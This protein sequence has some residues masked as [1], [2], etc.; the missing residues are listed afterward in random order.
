MKACQFPDNLQAYPPTLAPP[1]YDF[2]Q[3]NRKSFTKRFEEDE[4]GG[5]GEG[6]GTAFAQKGALLS[7]PAARTHNFLGK[8][9]RRWRECVRI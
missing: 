4:G 2:A 9:A 1:I 8:A 6:D 5:P 3:H 7:P